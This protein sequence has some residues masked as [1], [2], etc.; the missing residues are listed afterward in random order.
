MRRLGSARPS[1]SPAIPRP[2][3]PYTQAAHDHDRL[4]WLVQS[5]RPGR[6]RNDPAT[7]RKIGEACLALGRRAQ[8]RAWYQL[9]LSHDPGNADLQSDLAHIGSAP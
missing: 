9:A 7:L 2:L 4:E 6:R 8:A 1:C 3:D 5:A